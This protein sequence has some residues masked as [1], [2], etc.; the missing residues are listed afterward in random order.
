MWVREKALAETGVE[1]QVRCRHNWT[2]QGSDQ[3]ELVRDGE[4]PPYKAP[5][6]KA[7]AHDEELRSWG[8]VIPSK[9]PF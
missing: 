9:A 2:P 6:T 5:Q 1:V 7:S 4:L 8:R 3:S